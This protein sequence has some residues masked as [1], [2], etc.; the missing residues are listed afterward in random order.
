MIEIM[1]PTDFAVRLEFE[2][3]GYVLPEGSRFMERDIDFALEMIDFKQISSEEI[4]SNLFCSPEIIDTQEKSIEYNVVDIRKTPC[5]SVNK[6]EV[7]KRYKKETDS[8]Y[9]GVV[10][11]G[12]GRIASSSQS[13]AVEVGDK[14][15]VPFQTGE[16][17][18]ITD[19]GLQLYF[20]FP[21]K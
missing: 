20:V 8:F 13:I 2:R 15:F 17:K 16:L 19:E 18:F 1:E 9:V 11:K 10:T 4:K 3:G 21:P 12:K 7:N 6:L 5:F 14:F